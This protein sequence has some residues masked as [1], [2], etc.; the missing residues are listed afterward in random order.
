MTSA[1]VVGAGSF[2]ASIADRL[3]GS[4]YEVTLVDQFEP[5][6]SRA[7]SGAESRLIRGCHGSDEWYTR[8]ARRALDLWRE[9]GD[10]LF[11]PSG[12]TWFARRD[13]GFE[14]DSERTLRA[15]GIEVERHPPAAAGELMPGASQEGLAFVLYEPG[16]GVLRAAECVRALVR[17][18]R[19]RGAELVRAAARPDGADVLLGDGRRLRSD[20]VVWAAGAWLG[21]LF[22]ELVRL[23]VT[24]QDVVF[25][26][27]PPEWTTPPVPAFVEYDGAAYGLAA[28]DGHGVKIAPDVEGPDFDPNTR[29]R[30][31]RAESERLAREYM[32]VRFPA[33]AAA[34]LAAA[35]VCQYS[36][37]PDTNF[38]VAPHPEHDGVWIVGGG[39]GHGF[40]HGPALAEYV[41]ELLD[42]RAVPEPRFG[43]G[44]RTADRSLRT[45]G[46]QS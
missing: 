2:G 41:L 17:R 32:R 7:A 15:L 10:D 16:A 34:P 9:L 11:V 8:S 19:D 25:F 6:D 5:G 40:K 46:A 38:I 29:E 26:A 21:K 28:L 36:L 42:G 18:A 13:D 23:R 33:L 14:A 37:T 35:T 12:M 4:G 45:A 31:A 24:Q 43:L 22:P 30:H 20:V 44:A 3:A 39:S 27:G 1:T